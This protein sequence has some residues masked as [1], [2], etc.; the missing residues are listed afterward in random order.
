M[1]KLTVNTSKTKVLII[2]KGRHR[3]CQF[4]YNGIALDIVNS[5]KYLGVV[6]SSNGS[7]RKA[8]V[9]IAK[10][11]ERAMYNLLAKCK[12]L[13]LPI[14]MKIDL[15][16]KM[17]K[18]ILLYG[19]ECWGYG[20]NAVLEKVQLKFLKTI[21]GLK[22]CTASY[23]VYGE[24]GITPLSVDIEARMISFW[25]SLI[26]PVNA[27]LSATLYSIMLSN[28]M[29]ATN[30][31][32]KTFLWIEFVK[33][34][35]T[36][37]GHMYFW[38]SQSFPNRKWLY[39]N[40]KQKLTDLFISD[41]HAKINNDSKYSNYRLFKTTFEFEN[42][43]IKTPHQF[44]KFIIRF[45]TRNHRLP[46]ETGSWSGIKSVE[47]KCPLCKCSSSIA[48]EFHYLLECK[49]LENERKRFIDKKYYTN[50]N[51]IHFKSLMS[52]L[53]NQSRY[54]KLCKFIKAIICLF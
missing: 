14:D 48:D 19:C 3:T 53:N 37:C 27:K 21:L 10:Q 17:V 20:N 2:N 36:K 18:P 52:C 44:L 40:F 15:F 39:A 4:Y 41:F 1:W 31:N 16:N 7:F 33:N 22:S 34:V 35:F 5:F 45:R 26:N 54:I 47:R 30:R 12:N 6:F 42:Y 23:F 50:P 9:E 29:Y 8:K 43:L 32:S 49:S 11:A 28:F 25:S 24:T 13:A 51:V 38:D 46:I